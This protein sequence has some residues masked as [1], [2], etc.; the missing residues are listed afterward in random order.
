[1][2]QPQ[3]FWICKLLGF[4]IMRRYNLSVTSAVCW[5]ALT[6]HDGMQS[7]INSFLGPHCSSAADQCRVVELTLHLS[8]FTARIQLKLSQPKLQLKL[9]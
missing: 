6:D 5:S 7:S 3:L 4:K 2:E 9:S 8:I 1:M